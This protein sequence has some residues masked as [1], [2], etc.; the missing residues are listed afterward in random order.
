MAAINDLHDLLVHELNDLY[1]AEQ[2]I[3]EALPKLVEASSSP[4]L[5][6]AFSDHLLETQ[7][8]VKRLEQI[9]AKLG[10][11][12]EGEVC[13]AM[14]GILAEGN[15]LLSK[16]S[17]VDPQVLDAALV[18]AAQ[19]VEHYEIAAYGCARTYCRHLGESECETLLQQ[20]LD[21]EGHA[22]RL[23]TELALSGINLKAQPV[24]ASA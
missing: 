4:E 13:A 16:K 14:K 7:G 10:V 1:S 12:P 6:K 20:T 2:Q 24:A 15:K 23:L 9:F 3:L 21:E 11:E 17:K 5:R 18:G 19:R 22:N 8:H